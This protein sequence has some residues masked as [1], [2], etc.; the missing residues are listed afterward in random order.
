MQKYKVS[1]RG[2]NVLANLD[3]KTRRLGFFTS[4][5]VEAFSPEDAGSRATESIQQDDHVRQLLL[6][7]DPAPINLSV[8]EVQEIESFDPVHFPKTG[9]S[10]YLE[11]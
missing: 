2:R 5:F 3:G 4:V 11:K 7:G 10:I 9:L 6:N 8:E 1:I